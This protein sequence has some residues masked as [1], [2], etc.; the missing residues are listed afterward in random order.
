MNE[1]ASYSVEVSYELVFRK[2]LDEIS[3]ELSATAKHAP[4]EAIDKGLAI[5]F[6]AMEYGNFKAGDRVHKREIYH[7]IK[8]EKSWRIAS[9]FRPKL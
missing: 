8:T 3:T 7:F 2:S 9:E 4:F 6:K 5:F 1:D